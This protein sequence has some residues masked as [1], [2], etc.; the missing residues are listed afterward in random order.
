MPQPIEQ[1]RGRQRTRCAKHLDNFRAGLR[2]MTTKFDP[3]NTDTN[4]D[5]NTHT[6][7]SFQF[8]QSRLHTCAQSM[9]DTN[10][11]LLASL[12][13]TPNDHRSLKARTTGARQ[14]L[15]VSASLIWP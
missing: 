12:P 6:S 4:A 1:K 14:R 5:T 11:C 10:T 13:R 3:Q 15:D 9:T 8:T 2:A 7:L